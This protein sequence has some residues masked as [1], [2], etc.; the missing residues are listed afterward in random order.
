MFH[1]LTGI[2]G[3]TSRN[4]QSYKHWGHIALLRIGFVSEYD[5]LRTLRHHRGQG[6]IH[7]RRS[8]ARRME[9]ESGRCDMRHHER[10]KAMSGRH[11]EMKRSISLR[12]RFMVGLA[13][14]WMCS[15]DSVL[16]SSMDTAIPPASSASTAPMIHRKTAA[17]RCPGPARGGANVTCDAVSVMPIVIPD[18]RF[19]RE[20]WAWRRGKPFGIPAGRQEVISGVHSHYRRLG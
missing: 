6:W 1:G 14:S 13:M 17:L 4:P 8:S 5:R 2:A 3:G 15:I 11:T 10:W 20:Y 16:I 18:A 19:A 12:H 7:P 9:V